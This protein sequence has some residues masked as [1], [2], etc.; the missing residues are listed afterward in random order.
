MKIKIL[1]LHFEIIIC[2][3]LLCVFCLPLASHGFTS[4]SI[5]TIYEKAIYDAVKNSPKDMRETIEPHLEIMLAEIKP[6]LSE[7]KAQRRSY[8]DSYDL[9]VDL[10][11]D[12]KAFRNQTLAKEMVRI[13]VCQIRSIRTVNPVLSE[14]F[15]F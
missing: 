15:L 9:I 11:R 13:T 6:T 5:K 7:G 8:N 14:R 2:I 1:I 10:A 12:N 3:V 4:N